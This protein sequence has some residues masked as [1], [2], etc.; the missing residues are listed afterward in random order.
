MTRVRPEERGATAIL[1]AVVVSLV[2][3]AVGAIVIDI[4]TQRSARRDMQAVA[5][6]VALDLARQLDGRTAAEIQ[7]GDPSLQ[8]LANQSAAR[9]D[10]AIGD[11]V[12]VNPIL[13]EIS[14]DG[15]FVTV[16]GGEVPTAV[17]VEAHADVGFGIGS[18]LGL[19]SGAA[20]RA[21]VATADE[22]ACFSIGSYAARLDS[23]SSALLNAILGGILGGGVNLD[24]L[25][26]SGIANANLSLLDL[27]V[28][29]GLGS[30]DE[31][32]A[33]N[34]TA[35][36]LLVAAAQ[37]L[38]A[39]G[40]A[41]ANVLSLVGASIGGLSIA[42]SDLISLESGAGA[43]A[44]A[45]INALDLLAGTVLI[46]NGTNAIAI[47][48]LTTSLP[49]AGTNLTSTVTL[50]EKART[51][52]GKRGGSADT[53]QVALGISG[54]LVSIP[55]IL[56]LNPTNVTTDIGL[57]VASARGVLTDI[58]CGS[59]TEGDPSGLDIRVTSGAVGAKVSLTLDFNGTA[60]GAGPIN[61][62]I[63]GLTRLITGLL[64]P[65]LSIEI[66]GRLTVEATTGDPSE[67]R[68]AQIRVPPHE[69]G[70]GVSTGSGEL[71]LTSTNPTV[72]SSPPLSI[73][74]RSLLGTVNLSLQEETGIIDNLVKQVANT[75]LNPLVTAIN[76]SL[77]HPLYDILGL[78]VGGADVFGQRPSCSNPRLVG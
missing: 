47:P 37:V 48:A 51:R 15:S 72:T 1:T 46:A 75:V 65:I 71:G 41:D 53:A 7:G 44:T 68:P 36:D 23:S 58:I 6:V 38:A 63:S 17:K 21:A 3:F 34:I 18:S 25:S 20:N 30:V 57:T 5:D 45:T 8:A 78:S 28:Q 62:L 50:I 16:G 76:N 74:A 49:F 33:S 56:G 24:V 69:W 55:G 52:C 43:A 39:D 22:S 10:D 19:A 32:V 35:G 64:R 11:E 73:T 31:L 42:I 26:Y 54:S 77:L 61:G 67:V 2:L 70:Q 14:S 66:R 60:S 4:G 12:E 40:V 13:G 9:N 29:L 27:A 59:E